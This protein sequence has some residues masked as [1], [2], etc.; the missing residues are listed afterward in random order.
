MSFLHNEKAAQQFELYP[1]RMSFSVFL[2]DIPVDYSPQLFRKN[3]QNSATKSLFNFYNIFCSKWKHMLTTSPFTSS[4]L[5]EDSK[6]EL[7]AVAV[8]CGPVPLCRAV[9]RVGSSALRVRSFFSSILELSR[10]RTGASLRKGY[11]KERN[12]L[13]LHSL[14]QHLLF[15]YFGG[16]CLLSAFFRCCCGTAV[17]RGK[18]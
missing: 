11:G 17:A 2:F 5:E 3:I 1:I 4:C 9:W 7:L 6:H 8:M 16:A 14:R 18:Y 13:Q 15:C 12:W 10:S